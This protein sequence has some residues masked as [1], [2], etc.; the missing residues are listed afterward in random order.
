MSK[1][2]PLR[3]IL[4]VI[5]LFAF[6]FVFSVFVIHLIP[7]YQWE[8]SQQTFQLTESTFTL[9]KEPTQSV[10]ELWSLWDS[11]Y[12]VDIA[13]NGYTEKSFSTEN[14]EN[15]AFYPL[16]PLFIRIFSLAGL[17]NITFQSAFVVGL[18]VSNIFFVGAL[19]FLNKLLDYLEFSDGKKLAFFLVLMAFPTSY[20]LNLA[21]TES[22]FLFFSTAGLYFLFTKRGL[23]AFL[24]L[25]LSMI[26]RFNAVALLLPFYFYYFVS[27]NS[28]STDIKYGSNARLMLFSLSSLFIVFTPLFMFYSHLQ[29]LTGEFLA[30]FK[31][32]TAWN[33]A[34]TAPFSYFARYF[35]NIGF[36]VNY[37]AILTLVILVLIFIIMTASFIY[38][39]KQKELLYQFRLE[40]AT[41]FM[42]GLL[43]WLLIASVPNGASIIRYCLVVIPFFLIP[44]RLLPEGETNKPW[45][46]VVLFMLVSIQ[47]L[48]F[49]LFLIN[50][51]AYGF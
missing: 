21:Y 13:L 39:K 28:S 50:V 40:Y 22:L 32:Q 36:A 51:P 42:Y 38:F 18:I 26:T 43:S 29:S 47:S 9:Q 25:S 23:L 17:L 14:Y 16:Y 46:Y 27:S 24:M 10:V 33:N 41:L 44:I 3:F 6:R 12:Y 11:D 35:Q 2:T 5:V 48:F 49:T 45:F 7:H 31:I 30:S 4:I 20:F 15:W 19:Y 34:S 8:D 37:G 1:L